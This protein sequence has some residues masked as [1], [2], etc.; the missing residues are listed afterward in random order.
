MQDT[1]ASIILMRSALIL[2]DFQ[3]T[4]NITIYYKKN[5]SFMY[6]NQCLNVIAKTSVIESTY[7]LMNEK[8]NQCKKL[9][10]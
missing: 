10:D 9:C 2:M 4:N 8:I 5:G 6:N 1:R 7:H 3:T